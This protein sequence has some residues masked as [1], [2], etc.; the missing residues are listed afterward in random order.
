MA[1]WERR[2]TIS[3]VS[4]IRFS[5]SSGIVTVSPV[6]LP[7]GRA[8]LAAQPSPTGSAPRATIGIVDVAL[9]RG[10]AGFRAGRE[11]DI[12]TEPDEIGR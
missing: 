7:P 8:R 1:S 12:D 3:V 11:D 2:G 6:T 9:H 5:S 10:G 4:C